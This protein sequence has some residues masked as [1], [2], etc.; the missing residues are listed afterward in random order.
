MNFIDSYST[1][2][3]FFFFSLKKYTNLI[4]IEYS[5]TRIFA[6]HSKLNCLS[7]HNQKD[8]FPVE[9]KFDEENKQ[10]LKK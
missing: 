1:A 2:K 6:R 4:I 7:Y 5:V 9:L 8:I 3:L 10:T